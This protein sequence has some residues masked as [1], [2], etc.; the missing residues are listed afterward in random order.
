MADTVEEIL[1]RSCDRTGLVD[2][3]RINLGP[4]L[5]ERKRGEQ[6][7][8][9]RKLCLCAGYHIR[10]VEILKSIVFTFFK[11]NTIKK[12]VDRNGI[13]SAV[14]GIIS[15][16]TDIGAL[17][18]TAHTYHGHLAFDSNEQRD[19]IYLTT[20][21]RLII[22]SSLLVNFIEQISNAKDACVLPSP[23]EKLIEEF[24]RTLKRYTDENVRGIISAI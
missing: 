10:K 6:A 18:E 2:A 17:V 5:Q 21:M 15:C 1:N 24:D 7:E 3:V 14:D 11:H 19:A 12:N 20:C 8:M 22:E 4:I 16:E 23:P 13:S 9:F